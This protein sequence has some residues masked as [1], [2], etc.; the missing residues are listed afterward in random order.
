MRNVY[1]S[2]VSVCLCVCP[3]VPRRILT[4]LHGPGC[5]LVEWYGVL[6]SCALLGGIAIGA[7]V[8]LLQQHSANAKCQRVLCSRYMPGSLFL[9]NGS[10]GSAY[11][12]ARVYVTDR[13]TNR[14]TLRK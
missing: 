7:R 8:S 5:K 12:M 3:S 13:Q 1:W 11:P 9:A 2:R 14:Q 6:T 10:N 4:L